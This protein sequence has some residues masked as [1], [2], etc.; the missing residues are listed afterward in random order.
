MIGQVFIPYYFQ[1]QYLILFP[2]LFVSHVFLFS[3]KCIPDYEFVRIRYVLA[4][5]IAYWT[6]SY[7]SCIYNHRLNTQN[8]SDEFNDKKTYTPNDGNKLNEVK[9]KIINLVRTL[10]T[11]IFNYVKR[12]YNRIFKWQWMEMKG[13]QATELKSGKEIKK[14]EY[15]KR[16]WRIHV[17]NEA[18]VLV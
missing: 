17:L 18:S 8:E 10:Q 14:R 15:C 13:R 2:F 1:P 7:V 3:H 11:K 9:C 5:V 4:C 16:E 6:L 12:I